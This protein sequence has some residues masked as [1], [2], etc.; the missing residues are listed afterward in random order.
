MSVRRNVLLPLCWAPTTTRL[1]AAPD[2]SSHMGSRA[3]SNGLS[4]MP[5]TPLIRPCRVVSPVVTPRVGDTTRRPSRL[6]S[7]GGSASGG[8]HTWCA[9]GP[10]PSMRRTSTSITVSPCTSSA[11]SGSCATAAGSSRTAAAT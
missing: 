2:R 11:S 4:M 6:S 10:W 5:T 3:W 1:P 9:G 8:S 7:D